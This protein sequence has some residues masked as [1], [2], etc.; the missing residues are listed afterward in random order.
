M[1]VPWCH[2]C[3][4]R[5]YDATLRYWRPKSQHDTT[6]LWSRSV[7]ACVCVCAECL[8]NVSCQ[9]QCHS[10]NI[11]ILFHL[12]SFIEGFRSFIPGPNG[13]PRWNKWKQT[14]K[15]YARKIRSQI[16]LLRERETKSEREEETGDWRLKAHARLLQ[17]KYRN[18]FVQTHIIVLR[19]WVDD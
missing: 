1:A 13:R 19:R 3:C 17:S 10:F 9:R 11:S 7:C 8:W 2:G 15:P 4:C 16:A 14:Q 12:V 18:S 5:C 6:K